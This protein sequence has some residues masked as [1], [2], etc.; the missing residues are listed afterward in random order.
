[1][2]W[3]LGKRQW[4]WALTAFL[5]VALS[6]LFYFLLFRTTT[7][8]VALSKIKSVLNPVIYGFVI[9]YI[10]NPVMV[11]FEKLT[12]KICKRRNWHVG[13][14]R[15]KGIRIA[16]SFIALFLAL[17]IIYALVSSIVP[18]LIYSIR[19]IIMNFQTYVDNVNN[20][21]NET[22]HNPKF[23]E[24]TLKTVDNIVSSIQKWFNTEM[25]PQLDSLAGSVTSGVMG[26]VVFMKNVILGMIISMYLLIA[27]EGM[28]ARLRRFTYAVFSLEKGNRILNT[29]RFVNSKFGGFL[30][31]KV[32]DSAIIGLICYFACMIMRMP[33]A[34]LIAVII[35]AT[36]IIPFFGPFIGAVPCSIL[37]F[38]VDPIKSLIFI[39]FILCLQQFDGNFLGPKI[40]GNSVGVSSFM[41]IL[42][43]LIGGGFFGVTGMIVGVPLCAVIIAFVQTWIIRRTREK[44]LPNDLES[45]HYVQQINPITREFEQDPAVE[46]NGGF[47]DRIRFRG[48]DLREFDIKIKEKPW[49]RTY[50]QIAEEDARCNGTWK[51]NKT[52]EQGSDNKTEENKTANSAAASDAD[53]EDEEDDD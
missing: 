52:G 31:G 6:M 19:S 50:E 2:K 8:G 20:F 46:P 3:K 30:I 48:P 5:V 47:Y 17:I 32:I 23:D 39:I 26:F 49:E 13:N 4:V 35:G 53:D 38:V 24:K 27:K 7:L 14:K 10:L 11:F 51:E 9:A 33:Y 15:K 34:T 42:S 28:F 25:V 41:V 37:V 40:L 1:M 29:M 36:N 21:I 22:F 45:Y 43:I 16:C 18:E 44:G 12:Y